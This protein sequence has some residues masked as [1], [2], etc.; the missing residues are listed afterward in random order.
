MTKPIPEG[1][2]FA[3]GDEVFHF[4]D[5]IV[6]LKDSSSDIDNPERLWSYLREDG[7]LYLRGFH[8]RER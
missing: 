1:T 7:Y 5:D 2:P 4:G 8:D 6:A 3:F